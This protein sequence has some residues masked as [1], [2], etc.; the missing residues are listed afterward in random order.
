MRHE[1]VSYGYVEKVKA[2]LRCEGPVAG[3]KGMLE[4]RVR[5]TIKTV[6]HE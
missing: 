4:A 3:V 6:K 5:W 2:R 1:I